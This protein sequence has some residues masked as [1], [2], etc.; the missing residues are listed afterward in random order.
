MKGM[1]KMNSRFGRYGPKNY[2]SVAEIDP[3]ERLMGQVYDHFDEMFQQP[4]SANDVA[5]SS[6]DLHINLIHQFF[7]DCMSFIDASF[8]DL[9]RY[10]FLITN[11]IQKLFNLKRLLFIF[12]NDVITTAA[13]NAPVDKFD[14]DLRE[15]IDVSS[16]GKLL[17]INVN[18]TD[19]GSRALRLCCFLKIMFKLITIDRLDQKFVQ[20]DNTLNLLLK[21]E[22]LTLTSTQIYKL[23]MGLNQL[24]F[25]LYSN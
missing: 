2:P 15:L 22:I 7:V 1:S 13:P 10:K 16:F 11:Y 23:Y 12:F 19:I 20:I 5:S 14:L 6:Q 4:A 17:G 9:F 25:F 24:V 18:K 3:I 21:Q 8:S